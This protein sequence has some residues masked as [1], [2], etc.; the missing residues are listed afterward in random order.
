MKLMTDNGFVMSTTAIIQLAGPLFAAED[1][2]DQDRHTGWAKHH[3][4][5]NL[6]IGRLWSCW[7]SKPKAAALL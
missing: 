1:Q 4:D 6:A 2:D 5:G 3:V 7:D